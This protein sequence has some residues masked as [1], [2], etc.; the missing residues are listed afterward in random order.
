MA[1]G[2]AASEETEDFRKG[3]GEAASDVTGETE[4]FS[5]GL[6]P[7]QMA[8]GEVASPTEETEETEDFRNGG[9]ARSGRSGR[10]GLLGT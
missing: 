4:N 1:G 2:E 8:G 10:A 6:D 3:G 7:D 9:G 5:Q